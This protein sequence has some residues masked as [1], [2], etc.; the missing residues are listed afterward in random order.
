M[1]K[2]KK[3]ACQTSINTHP[4]RA[5]EGRPQTGSRSSRGE[6][7]SIQQPQSSTAVLADR[8]RGPWYSL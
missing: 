4:E 6:H 5:P 7:L 1:K 3:H 2:K 8:A